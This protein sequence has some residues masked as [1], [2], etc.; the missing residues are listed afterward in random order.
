MNNNELYNSVF[1]EMDR[2]LSVL[3]RKTP[4]PV[5]QQLEFL[6]SWVY[7]YE[8][9][10][11]HQAI[12]LK[13]VRKVSGLRTTNI[14]MANGFV[15]EQASLHRLLDELYEDIMFLVFSIVFNDITDL[16]REFLEAF[17]SEELV[18][19]TAITSRQKRPIIPRNK[20][21]SYLHQKISTNVS[22][23]LTQEA[24]RTIFK[25]NSGYLHSAAPQ[26]LELYFGNP[27]KFHTNGVTGTMLHNQ[28]CN[29]FCNYVY[30]GIL[31]FSSASKAL[32]EDKLSVETKNFAYEFTTKSGM[33]NFE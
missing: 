17:Y 19:E 7:R 24:A 21:R 33:L 8:E 2:I 5:K 25:L 26:I 1:E 6:N 27:P 11:S 22:Q 10:T 9:K 23:N 31:C 3:F 18:A 32:G 28:F 16:H 15:Q 13:L 14:V 12:L 4:P 20:I 30:R 29:N